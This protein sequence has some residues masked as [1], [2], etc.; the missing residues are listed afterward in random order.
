MYKTRVVLWLLV[1]LADI[2]VV[3]PYRM[4]VAI[5]EE[6]SESTGYSYFDIEQFPSE[7]SSLF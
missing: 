5:P 4:D 2:A 6:S 3:E 7:N 1:V